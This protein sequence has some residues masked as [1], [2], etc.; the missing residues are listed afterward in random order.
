MTISRLLVIALAAVGAASAAESP[1]VQAAARAEKKAAL[2][3]PPLAMEFRLRAAVAL[4]ERYPAQSRRLLDSTLG[5]LRGG[6]D[7]AMAISVI[8]ALVELSPKD[9]VAIAPYLRVWFSEALVDRLV[10]TKHPAEAM[11]LFRETAAR[12][13]EPLAPADATWL[14]DERFA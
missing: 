3:P 9:A 5:E 14:A 12:L 4:H 13:A 10:R 7:R 6:W 8:E 2:A 11:A 1:V